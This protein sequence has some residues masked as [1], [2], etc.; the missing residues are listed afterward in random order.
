MPCMHIFPVF[1]IETP[2]SK[3]SVASVFIIET[4]VLQSHVGGDAS[5]V[6]RIACNVIWLCDAGRVTSYTLISWW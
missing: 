1:V 3:D 6:A 2:K 5:R 4:H